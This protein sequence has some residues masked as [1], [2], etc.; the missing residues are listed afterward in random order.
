M[1]IETADPKG[2][3]ELELDAEHYEDQ[4]PLK[5]YLPEDEYKLF[6]GGIILFFEGWGTE[7][8]F[9]EE[10]RRTAEK[11]GLK[12]FY[13]EGDTGIYDTDKGF[14][15]NDT[16]HKYFT[17]E[18]NTDDVTVWRNKAL[19]EVLKPVVL[20]LTKKFSQWLRSSFVSWSLQD[21]N[22]QQLEIKESYNWPTG[23]FLTKESAEQTAR[24]YCE[25]NHLFV[26]ETKETQKYD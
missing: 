1:V 25:E 4:K 3:F 7:M 15:T 21:T 20:V 22:G 23:D 11:A 26:T 10:I 18:T 17:S 9:A 13:L 24:Q 19:K 2:F 16:Q 8:E 6:K 12:V 14:H 5:T